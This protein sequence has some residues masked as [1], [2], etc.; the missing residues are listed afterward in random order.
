MSEKIT[1]ASKSTV[2]REL[3]DAAKAD[4][5]AIS[6]KIDELSLQWECKKTMPIRKKFPWRSS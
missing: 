5:T 1:L 4:Y 3:L 2:R 6:P